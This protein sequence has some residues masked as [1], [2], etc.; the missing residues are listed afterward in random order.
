M[1]QKFNGNKFGTEDTTDRAHKIYVFGRGRGASSLQ[2]SLDV[3]RGGAMRSENVGMSNHN[4]PESGAHRKSKVSLAM[5]ISQGL[6]GPNVLP[7]A[8]HAD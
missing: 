6:G 5:T 8:R 2:R 1:R 4:A 3:S 7:S